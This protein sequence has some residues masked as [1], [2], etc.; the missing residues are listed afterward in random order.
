MP[1]GAWNPWRALRA[2]S[3]TT[4]VLRHLDGAQ[5]LAIIED[6]QEVIEL[7]SGLGR[8][9]RNSVLAHELIHLE[10]GVPP[11]GAP[12]A[13]V[14]KEEHWVRQETARRLVPPDN[15]AD[16]VEDQLEVGEAVTVADVAER[17]EVSGDVAREAL[18][19]LDA[20]VAAARGRH[21]SGLSPRPN[22]GTGHP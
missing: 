14:E 15:L 2:R 4:L 9:D 3:Q 12:P 22:G 21:P 8:I 18:R 19:L 5:G 20:E 11:V 13:L 16:W 10:R 6:G 1:V 17:W 7:H